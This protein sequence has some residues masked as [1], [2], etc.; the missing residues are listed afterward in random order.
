MKGLRTAWVSSLGDLSQSS[1]PINPL[2]E[3][4]SFPPP[5]TLGLCLPG[6]ALSSSSTPT[7]QSQSQAL[8]QSMEFQ[9]DALMT[10]SAPSLREGLEKFGGSLC[11][12][13]PGFWLSKA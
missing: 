7:L 5:I 8:Q 13:G 4:H 1:A 2:P 3:G 9:V 11:R 10:N 12:E 6:A